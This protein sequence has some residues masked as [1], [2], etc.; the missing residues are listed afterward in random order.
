M[1][2]PSATP[3]PQILCADCRIRLTPITG[4]PSLT[5]LSGR[6]DAIEPCDVCEKARKD[7]VTCH[8]IDEMKREDDEKKVPI[9]RRAAISY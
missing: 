1:P 6:R 3:A 8:A 4:L 7:A 5:L 9:E 2:A